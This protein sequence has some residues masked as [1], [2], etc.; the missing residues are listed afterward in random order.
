VV[1]FYDR[2][3][4]KVKA[5]HDR[6]L[7]HFSRLSAERKSRAVYYMRRI[8]GITRH[9]ITNQVEVENNAQSL[10]SALKVSG[11][12]P[13]SDLFSHLEADD[14]IEIYSLD[15][16]QIWRNCNVM[17]ICSYTLE[18]IHSFDWHERYERCESD[19]SAILGA[20]GRLFDLGSERHVHARIPN[21]LVKE[22][23]SEKRFQLNV[24]HDYFFP[25]VGEN[26]ELAAFLVTS[27]V[28]I[29]PRPASLPAGYARPV[30][31]PSL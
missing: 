20:I 26:S 30:R 23:F 16:I 10:W 2:F 11:L 15:G 7:P 28:E 4:I 19:N 18:E 1:S 22:K 21:H 25:L 3:G 31:E 8:W 12:K 6:S 5:Y 29:L 27:K 17:E 24:R 13:G 9:H 14:K